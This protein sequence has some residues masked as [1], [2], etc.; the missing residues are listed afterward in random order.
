VADNSNQAEPAPSVI[1]TQNGS[2][3]VRL[4]V[5]D[6]QGGTA[7]ATVNVEVS[8]A[9][10]TLALLPGAAQVVEGQS[11]TLGLLVGDPGAQ[12]QPWSYTINWGDGSTLERGSVQARGAHDVAHRYTVAGS[13]TIEVT[14]TDRDG[15]SAEAAVAVE[16]L[17][18][19]RAPAVD[20]GGPYAGLEGGVIRRHPAGGDRGR[21]GRRRARLRVGREWRRRRRQHQHGG[22]RPLGDL[23]A[24]RE[25]HRSHHRP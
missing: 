12:D 2:Y 19:N 11:F 3:P 13:R 15:G 24:G 4:T 5:G 8:N 6:G 9:P 14:L 17:A 23:H 22:A 25:L 7:S 1:F 20:A 21:P 18:A 16:V 10:P